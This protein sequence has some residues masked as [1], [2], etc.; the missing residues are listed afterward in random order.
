MSIRL[1]TCMLEMRPDSKQT[2]VED[3]LKSIT[4]KETIK[5]RLQGGL[6]DLKIPY[7]VYGCTARFVVSYT[8]PSDLCTIDTQSTTSGT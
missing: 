5:R 8:H 2:Q 7:Y 6:L 1:Y 3:F 4:F